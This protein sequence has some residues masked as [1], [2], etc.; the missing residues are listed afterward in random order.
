LVKNVSVEFTVKVFGL[1]SPQA[2]HTGVI[3]VVHADNVVIVVQAIVATDVFELTYDVGGIEQVFD[4]VT[5]FQTVTVVWD[6]LNVHVAH[7]TVKV[8]EALSPQ[9]HHTGVISVVHADNVVIVVQAIVATDVFELTY[10]V[11]G[12]VQ[13]FDIV[14]LVHCV[15]VVWD[16]LN[17]HV[18]HATVKVFEALS[19]QAHHT[20]VMFVVHADS[21]VIVVQATVATDVFELVYDVGDTVQVFDIVTLFQTVTVVWDR[22][23]VH[24]AHATLQAENV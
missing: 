7:A 10:D 5:L 20:G 19:P 16:R 21:V 24:V 8:F 14:T 22:L 18:A 6:R 3:F 11:G 9:A 12:T 15:T 1:L 17:V 2:H 13:V 23:N 4:I